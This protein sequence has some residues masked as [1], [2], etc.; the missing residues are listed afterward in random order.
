VARTG[1]VDLGVTGGPPCRPPGRP[2][3]R[4]A[5]RGG[6]ALWGGTVGRHCGAALWAVLRV[7]LVGPLATITAAHRPLGRRTVSGRREQRLL[8]LR[9]LTTPT[10]RPRDASALPRPASPCRALP[11]PAAPCRALPRPAAPCLTL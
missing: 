5:R 10:E 11:R 4:G 6:A 3:Q 8:H 9:G 7:S 1:A 2:G